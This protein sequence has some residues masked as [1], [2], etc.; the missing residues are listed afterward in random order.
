MDSNPDPE[1]TEPDDTSSPELPEGILNALDG[2]VNEAIPWIIENL[3]AD[4]EQMLVFGAPKVGKSQFALQLAMCVALGEPFLNWSIAKKS[5]RVLYLNFE[6]GKRSFMLRIARHY[7]RLM[8]LKRERE[9]E[10]AGQEYVENTGLWHHSENHEPP[11]GELLEKINET[12]KDRLFFCGELKGLHGDHV[13]K[14]P[15]SA[16]GNKQSNEKRDAEAAQEL[17]VQHWQS[18]IEAVK[19]DLVIFDTLSKSHSVN[20]SDN[21]EIQRVLGWI[22]KICSIPLPAADDAN[23]GIRKNDARK[24]IAHIIVHHARKMPGE[25]SRKGS[26]YINLDSIRGG[27]AIRAEADLIFGIFAAQNKQTSTH[28]ATNRTIS[29]E[30]RNL[31]PGEEYVNFGNFAFSHPTQRTPEDEEAMDDLLTKLI[32][33]AFVLSKMRGLMIGTLQAMVW[34]GLEKSGKDREYTKNGLKSMLES[35]AGQND[36][37]FEIRVKKGVE[38]ETAKFPHERKGG[39]KIFWIR[40]GA[41]WLDEEPL[42]GAIER[43]TPVPAAKGRSRKARAARD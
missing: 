28:N 33:D 32:R 14:P 41:A 10:E 39:N 43:H 36:S 31:A 4:G 19:P 29:I 21:S 38:E 8:E 20:E 2:T 26:N 18:I 12:I 9:C 15:D 22:R 30:A 37:K 7:S 35:L 3:L 5:G 25:F 23:S 24:D 6:M 42:K 34:A 27:S 1:L 16:T 13:P 11:E 17:L 40:D